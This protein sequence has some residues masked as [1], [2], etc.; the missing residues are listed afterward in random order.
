MRRLSPIKLAD[1]IESLAEH[2]I[3]TNLLPEEV[4]DQFERRYLEIALDMEGTKCAVSRRLRVHRNTLDRRL[5][6]LGVKVGRP[7]KKAVA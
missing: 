4:A 6:K 1:M 5:A 3:D 7:T 2:A